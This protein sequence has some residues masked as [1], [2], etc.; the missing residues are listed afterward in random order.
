MTRQRGYL[1]VLLL[2]ILTGLLL[3]TLALIGNGQ[4]LRQ[5]YYRQTMVD[6][7]AISAAVLMAREMNLLAIMNRAILANQLHL[8][9]VLTAGYTAAAEVHAN[10]LLVAGY[11]LLMQQQQLDNLYE[12]LWHC[13]RVSKFCANGSLQL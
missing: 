6:N 1:S 12:L 3:L 8:H 9:D 2:P 11:S 4:Q 7:L 13:L 10:D 5:H